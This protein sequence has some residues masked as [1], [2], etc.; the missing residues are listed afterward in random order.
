MMTALLRR[1]YHRLPS[2]PSTNYHLAQ[3]GVDPYALI[4]E[5]GTVVDVGAGS[6][7]GHYAFGPIAGRRFRRIGVDLMPAPGIACV[8]DAHS[9]PFASGSVDAVLC[10]SVLEYVR[11]PARVAEEFHRIL[12]PGG[13]VYLSAPFVF[14]YHGPP[15]DLY[16]FSPAGIRELARD[17]QTIGLGTHRGPA[18]T[19][20]H[21]TVHFLAILFSFNSTRAYGVLLDLFK[22][23]LFWMKYADRW[24]GRYDVARVLHGSSFFLGR[25]A[26]TAGEPGR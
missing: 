24:I 9:L 19:F 5:G 11:H 18:S 23:G 2:P 10:V 20:C 1:A 3:P 16:R 6:L 12:K 21:L 13:V 25:K 14:P 7:T 26:A 15:E 4:P 8:A 17:F 22:W